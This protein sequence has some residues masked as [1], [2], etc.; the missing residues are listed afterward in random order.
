MDALVSGAILALV[1]VL[2]WYLL[3]H[4]P[5]CEC[6]KEGF[7]P[8]NSP[9]DPNAN[10]EIDVAMMSQTMRTAPGP[11]RE[12]GVLPAQDSEDERERALGSAALGRATLAL[13][14]FDEQDGSVGAFGKKWR[15]ETLYSDRPRRKLV[16][17][18]TGPLVTAA[19]SAL[20]TPGDYLN[21]LKDLTQ[22]G[23]DMHRSDYYDFEAGTARP[24]SD[25]DPDMKF[26]RL[27][28]P[29][30]DP[31]VGQTSWL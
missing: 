18:D 27:T 6:K 22:D 12:P 24:V 17:K 29:D 21:T 10:A 13:D 2:V 25:G 15:F 1:L 4:V 23:R 16:G 3:K 8:I 11:F 19:S 30:E 9:C 14:E 28:E 26:R 20:K 7:L 5:D 31:Y